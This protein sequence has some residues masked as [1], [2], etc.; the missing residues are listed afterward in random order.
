MGALTVVEVTLEDGELFLRKGNS[1]RPMIP[2][3]ETAFIVGGFGY[4]FTVE[5]DG[6]AS[7]I[8]EVHVSGAWPFERVD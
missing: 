2:Q 6:M 4:V 1:R 3:T 7:T 8:S 5:D